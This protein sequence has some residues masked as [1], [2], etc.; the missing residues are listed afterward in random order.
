M[1]SRGE[2]AIKGR[3]F[4]WEETGLEEKRYKG[5]KK[6]GQEMV[7]GITAYANNVNWGCLGVSIRWPCP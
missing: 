5:S 7:K 4:I 3:L 2:K 1:G 6:E